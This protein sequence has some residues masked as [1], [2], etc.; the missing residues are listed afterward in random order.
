MVALLSN[1]SHVDAAERRLFPRKDLQLQVRGLRMDHSLPAHREPSL[2]LHTRDV[3]AGG[4]SAMSDRPLS[5]GERLN[6]IFPRQGAGNGWDIQGRV[7]R[8]QPSALGWRIAVEFD[9]RPA[10]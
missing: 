10:A 3:S 4:L 2:E 5:P 9:L 1:P 7:L 8:C 6:V